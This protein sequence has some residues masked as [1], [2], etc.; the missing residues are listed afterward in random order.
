M[1][2]DVP[3]RKCV[4][5]T[6]QRAVR[7]SIAV[8]AEI[9]PHRLPDCVHD[10]RLPHAGRLG[11][12]PSAIFSHIQITPI[13]P[14]ESDQEVPVLETHSVAKARARAPRADAETARP[15]PSVSFFSP[16]SPIVVLLFRI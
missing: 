9:L 10:A 3:M 14:K 5:P 11:Q 2:N 6:L 4:A 7:E 1:F 15:S 8:L 12:R 16:N 13:V